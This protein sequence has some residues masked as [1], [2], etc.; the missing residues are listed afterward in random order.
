[1]S[2]HLLVALALSI[3]AGPR[4][5]WLFPA[6]IACLDH[7]ERLP[8]ACQHCGQNDVLIASLNCP[9]GSAEGSLRRRRGLGDW[10]MCSAGVCNGQ[11]RKAFRLG[12]PATQKRDAEV[13]TTSAK[14]PASLPLFPSQL[15]Q[16]TAEPR[17]DSHSS[18]SRRMARR[19]ALLG[20]T[21]RP[22]RRQQSPSTRNL[23]Y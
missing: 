1:M 21:L 17:L 3:L 12:K 16:V 8:Q 20:A 10:D 18:T 6:G 9:A 22:L 15:Y 13:T 7:R 11:G 2:L 4:S 14:S 23:A 19:A 5:D